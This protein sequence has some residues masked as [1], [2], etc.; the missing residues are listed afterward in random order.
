MAVCINWFPITCAY[1]EGDKI[2]EEAETVLLV[3]THADYRSAVEQLVRPHISYT[4]FIAE[5]APEYVIETRLRRGGNRY[6]P[7]GLSSSAQNR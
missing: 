7:E 3:K 1:R 5:T 2:V 6:P 4:N